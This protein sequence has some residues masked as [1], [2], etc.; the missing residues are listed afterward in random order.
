MYSVVLYLLNFVIIN[1]HWL[2]SEQ[3]RRLVPVLKNDSF[4][5][6]GA[7]FT[8]VIFVFGRRCHDTSA[9]G[10]GSLM[11]KID[12]ICISNGSHSWSSRLPLSGH[13]MTG[14]HIHLPSATFWHGLSTSKFYIMPWQKP[15]SEYS[16]RSLGVRFTIHN[17]IYILYF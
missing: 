6:H 11:A 7:P 3:G 17:Y 4:H 14:I 13:V 15:W 5:R 2:H 9:M 8:H 12:W 16:C 1:G 10:P